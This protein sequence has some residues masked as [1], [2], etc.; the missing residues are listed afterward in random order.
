MSNLHSAVRCINKRV[1]GLCWRVQRARTLYEFH[2]SMDALKQESPAAARYLSN[3]KNKASQE[4]AGSTDSTEERNLACWC[5]AFALK[6]GHA[7]NGVRTSNFVE[8]E[9]SRFLESRWKH[10]L[11]FLIDFTHT[12]SRLVIVVRA[13]WSRLISSVTVS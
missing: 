9:N 4:P 10:P 6:L 7:M 11:F 13:E 8:Q 1:S 12:V 3:V 5:W 2:E